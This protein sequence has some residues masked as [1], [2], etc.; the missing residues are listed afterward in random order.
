MGVRPMTP[1]DLPG[2]LNLGQRMH[3]ESVYRQFDYDQNKFGRLL[4]NYVLRTEDRF[5]YVGETRGALSGIFLGSIGAHYFGN[6]LVASDTLWYVAP[7]ARGSRT[8]VQLLRAYEN[9]AKACGASAI[10]V[11]ISSGI[12]PERTGNMMQKLGYDVA[13]G[14]YKLRVVV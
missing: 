9:W 7:E 10:Y 12:T 3:Q 5:A 14:N 8:G 13:A 4:C 2:A 6:D 11:G 1:E